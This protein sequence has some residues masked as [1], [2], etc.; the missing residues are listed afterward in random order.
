MQKKKVA[1]N[2]YIY[3]R[4]NGGQSYVFRGTVN[5][6]RIERG[7]GVVGKISIREA[8]RKVVE[9]LASA[10]AEE[11]VKTAVTFGDV[12]EEAIEDIE[13]LRRW[14]NA[15]SYDGWRFSIR[16][17]ALPVLKDKPL[18]AITREDCLLLP[19]GEKIAKILRIRK[20]N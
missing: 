8:K 17:Y 20:K 12:W 4:D 5:G 10:P 1:E 13:K 16:A 2:L 6:K 7:L 15:A 18:S 19:K 11:K 9:I 3:T 14:K